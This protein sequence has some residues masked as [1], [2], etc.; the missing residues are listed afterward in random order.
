[1]GEIPIAVK[2]SPNFAERKRLAIIVWDSPYTS[3]VVV[4]LIRRF[5]EKR[6]NCEGFVGCT[7]HKKPKKL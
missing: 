6:K 2:N 1:M 5:G 7:C 3:Y 4:S